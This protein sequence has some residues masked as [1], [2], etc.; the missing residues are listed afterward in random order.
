M[1][2]VRLLPLTHAARLYEQISKEN[3]K[4]VMSGIGSSQIDILWI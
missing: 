3:I 1:E 4:V 2:D